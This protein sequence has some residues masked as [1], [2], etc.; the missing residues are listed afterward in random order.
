MFN[1]FGEN[2]KSLKGRVRA[3]EGLRSERSQRDIQAEGLKC[4]AQ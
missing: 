4:L 3:F 1:S 2:N